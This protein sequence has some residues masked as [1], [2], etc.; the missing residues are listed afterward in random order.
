MNAPEGLLYTK[1]HEWVRRDGD[2]ATVG[3]TDFAQGELGDIVFVE[4]PAKGTA[5]EAGREFGTVESV[6]A[7]SE[8]F[9]PVS[10]TV[11]EVNTALQ[12]TPEVVNTDPYGEGWILKVKGARAEELEGLMASAA[13][14]AF[15][16]HGEKH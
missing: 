12:D 15:V 16:Q 4:L 9:A 14:V 5:L 3:I 7:V 10:G 6:K 2:V 1:D 13:Y 8:V 11:V